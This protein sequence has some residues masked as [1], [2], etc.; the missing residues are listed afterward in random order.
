MKRSGLW[1]FA[2]SLAAFTLIVWGAIGLTGSCAAALQADA[3]TT[4]LGVG[5]GALAPGG[6]GGGGPFP[7]RP[8][9][10]L[11]ASACWC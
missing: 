3:R 8:G 11:W 1:V 7:P 2:E 6:G 10:R 5:G 4:A 9:P